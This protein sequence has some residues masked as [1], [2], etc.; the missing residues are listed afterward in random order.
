MTDINAGGASDYPGSLDTNTPETAGESTDLNP[1]DGA[2][3]AIIA[4]QTELGLDPAGSKDTVKAYLLTEHNA[5][6]THKVVL[7]LEHNADGTHKVVLDAE[8]NA[9]GEHTYK[10]THLFYQDN[11]AASQ[12]AVALNLSK[13][14][15]AFTEVLMPYAGSIVGIA[16]YSNAARTADTLTVDATINGSV[17]GLQA[18]LDGT[19]TTK[20][21]STQAIA[22]DAFSAEDLIG[23]KITT[24]GSWTPTT[25]DIAVW[26]IVSLNG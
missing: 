22:A 4:V 11:V 24:G 16:V 15:D 3:S 5:D 13:T 2:A 7:D 9:A 1:G 8:H 14:G 25:A 17:T 21:S 23:V 18:V 19:N 6:G 10:D 26:V 20:N 12:S